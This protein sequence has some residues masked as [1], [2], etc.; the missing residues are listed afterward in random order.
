MGSLGLDLQKICKSLL[1]A[2][3]PV[4]LT[5]L[6]R[7]QAIIQTKQSTITEEEQYFPHWQDAAL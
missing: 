4:G 7:E 6:L 5:R 3:E 1:A 2:L